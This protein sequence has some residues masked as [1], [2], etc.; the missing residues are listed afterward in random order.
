[1]TNLSNRGGMASRKSEPRLKSDQ[2]ELES[3]NDPELEDHRYMPFMMR[4]VRLMSESRRGDVLE[5]DAR[6]STTTISALITPIM[7]THLSAARPA[8][9]CGFPRII[10]QVVQRSHNTLS[11]FPLLRTVVRKLVL[12][13]LY[14]FS[15][16]ER[17]LQ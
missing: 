5:T 13:Y 11:A 10:P 1:V 8:L 7:L 4:T 14:F 16:L 2:M 15:V 9:H 6:K 12:Y 3:G 17:Q